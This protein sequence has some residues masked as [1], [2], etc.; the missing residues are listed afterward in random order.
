MLAFS[1][2]IPCIE[3]E[4]VFIYNESAC[5]EVFFSWII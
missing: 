1:M 2:N 4:S 3:N 5:K